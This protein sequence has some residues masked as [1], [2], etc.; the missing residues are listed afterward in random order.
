MFQLEFAYPWFNP[1]M[2][3]SDYYNSCSPVGFG[4]STPLNTQGSQAPLSGGGYGGAIVY[5]PFTDPTNSYREYLEVPLLAPLQ[6]GQ[7]Y[8]VAFN[9]S[10][11]DGSA[12]AVAEIGAYLSV[13]PV[14][15]NSTFT[16]FNFTPQVEN[17]S[18]NLLSS[19]NSWTLVQGTFIAAGGEDHLTLGN[20][21]G[22]ANTTF[23]AGNGPSKRFVPTLPTKLFN[24]V[25]P[26]FLIDRSPT[27]S[28]PA[29]T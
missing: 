24:A 10:L 18:Y 27:I 6:A 17:P 21:H 25:R 15:S 23:A 4:V 16:V 5:Y 19:S 13:G 9:V 26:S 3:T 8:R 2:A 1:S 22:N 28:A 14:I 12:W 7:L 11:A 20:F 29:P